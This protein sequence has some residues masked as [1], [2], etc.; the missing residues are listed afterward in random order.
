VPHC[1]AALDPTAEGG[2]LHVVTGGAGKSQEPS[3]IKIKGSEPK[4][5]PRTI[6]YKNLIPLTLRSRDPGLQLSII[7]P[8]CRD[9]V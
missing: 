2:C 3:K 4:C 8:V 5:P 6:L 1:R 7:P 9:D